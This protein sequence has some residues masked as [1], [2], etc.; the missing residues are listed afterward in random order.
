[1]NLK[2]RIAWYTQ[3]NGSEKSGQSEIKMGSAGM[4]ALILLIVWDLKL[5]I[6]R[7]REVRFLE[8]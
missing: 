4:L 5:Q 8:K 2:I 7:L 1:M 6:K 3:M